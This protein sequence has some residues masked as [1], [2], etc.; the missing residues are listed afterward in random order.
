MIKTCK[1]CKQPFNGSGRQLY[2]KPNCVPAPTPQDTPAIRRQLERYER[3]V[4]DVMSQLQMERRE[5]ERMKVFRVQYN[6]IRDYL[7]HSV[8]PSIEDIKRIVGL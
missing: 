5:T 4:I 1:T 7:T 8:E 2:C 3:E 6:R